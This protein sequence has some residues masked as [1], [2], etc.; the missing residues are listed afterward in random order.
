MN[1]DSSKAIPSLL[2][3]LINTN[4]YIQLPKLWPDTFNTKIYAQMTKKN[5]LTYPSLFFCKTFYSSS[6]QQI[7][8][9][10]FADKN[11]KFFLHFFTFIMPIILI[12]NKI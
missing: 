4:K 7:S 6:S 5:S 9:Y 3:V 1:P 10:L 11:Y 12:V 8:I 2:P